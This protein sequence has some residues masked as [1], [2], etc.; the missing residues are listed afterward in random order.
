MKVSDAQ[1]SMFHGRTA[2]LATKHGKSAAIA[3]PLKDV[4]DIHLEETIHLDTDKFGSFSG[5]TPR[6]TSAIDAARLKIYHAMQL[7]PD[8]NL[9]LA[10]EGSFYAHPDTP[11]TMVDE[12]IVVLYDLLNGLEITGTYRS[13]NCHIKRRVIRSISEGLSFAA[14]AGFPDHGLLIR[15]E[16]EGKKP[17]F[18]MGARSLASLEAGLFCFLSGIN[19]GTKVT[20]ES[21]LRANF[22]PTRMANIHEAAKILA[23]NMQSVC[24]SCSSPGYSVDKSVAGLPC[25]LCGLPTGDTHFQIMRCSKC[26][27][28]ERKYFPSGRITAD[29]G[30]CYFCN[31]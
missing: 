18:F 16:I 29:P 21:D 24:P 12:E 1:I 10:S 11:I 27:H 8:G 15:K 20:M 23:N 22:N 6:K 31:P 3:S 5:S 25:D 2:I 14:E 30:S 13:V 28:S 19:T 4:F 26:S 9:F 17:L 7:H